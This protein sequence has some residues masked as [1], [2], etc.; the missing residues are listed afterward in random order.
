MNSIELSVIMPTYNEEDIILHSISKVIEILDKNEIKFE[1]IIVDDGGTDNTKK[2]AL[3]IKDQR[4][5][6]IGY[7]K[8][9][10]KGFALKYG[11]QNAVGKYIIFYDSDLDIPP[12]EIVKFLDIIKKTDKDIVIGS[13][14]LKES[15][16]EYPLIRS[17]LSISY[18]LFV[19]LLFNIK[20]MDTQT[21]IKIFKKEVLDN[22][23]EKTFV[24]KYA[25]DIEILV[26]ATMLNYTI[27][28]SPVK[29]NLKSKKSHV[30]FKNIAAMFIDTFAIF[31]RL[32]ITRD[33]KKR[34][35]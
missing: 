25:Y 8:N 32:K 22:I 11:Y 13:K 30:K 17:I 2:N 20:V 27:K 9:A 4:V 21:G 12:E 1:L 14:R 26:I 19:K 23:M 34:Y 28:E 5:K 35:F 3:S 24:N 6:I 10:G 15:E 29:I 33:K 7:K 16:V 31:Y 18:H